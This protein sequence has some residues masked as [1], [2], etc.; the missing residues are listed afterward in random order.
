MPAWFM[1]TRRRRRRWLQF[2][3]KTL[4]TITLTFVYFHI[5]AQNWIGNRNFLELYDQSDIVVIGTLS[6][7]TELPKDTSDLSS[8]TMPLK[9]M[10]LSNVTVLKGDIDK[11]LVYFKDIY[12]GCGYA[13]ILVENYLSR[14][15]LIFARIRND[16]IFQIGSMNESPRDI[17]NS[18]LNYNR[19]NSPLTSVKMT[20]W[21]FESAKNSDLFKLLNYLISFK[22]PPVFNKADSI[23]FTNA[24]RNW[25]YKK[26]LSFD[27]YNYDNEGIV[28]LLA[29]Y[30]DEEY[31]KILKAYLVKLKNEPYS[32]VDDL[33]LNI[34]KATGNIELKKIIDKF[35]NEWRETV[36]KKLIQDFI[37]R[38]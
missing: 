30:K 12:N 31:K 35:Q 13:P 22:E 32:E 20:T 7:I 6:D 17:A 29:R 11:Q 5:Q 9:S 28:S 21:F 38:I 24:Q 4:L 16:S 10:S 36:R 2:K 33:M 19:I 34:Y 18:I 26:L 14:E 25:L 3:M 1:R 37:A 23:N 8:F 15:T 27:G